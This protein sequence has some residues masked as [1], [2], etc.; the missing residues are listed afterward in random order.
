MRSFTP[1][2]DD[3]YVA[4]VD[5]GSIG[6]AANSFTFTN[7]VRLDAKN[8]FPGGITFNSFG[9]LWGTLIMSDQLFLLTPEGNCQ[10]L[11]DDRNPQAT[12]ALEKTFY[13]SRVTPELML[14]ASGA[15]A[16]WA[17]SAT[18]GGP[19]LKTVYL[20]SLRSTR[21]PYFRSP[22]AGRPMVHW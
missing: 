7:E 3:G 12:D 14:A 8:G 22:I 15:I 16:Q 9:N 2:E 13:E 4:L 19:H 10:I 17:A 6:I 21:I 5:R 18:F 11:F 1:D 20:S